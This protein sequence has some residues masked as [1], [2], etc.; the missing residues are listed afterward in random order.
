MIRRIIASLLVSLAPWLSAVDSY[1]RY[2]RSHPSNLSHESVNTDLSDYVWPTDAGNIGTSTFGEYRRTH[3]HEGIDIST[4]NT[5]GY[6]V[7]AVRDGYVARIRI[8]PVGYGKMLYVRHADGY[9]STYAHLSHF[10][11]EIDSVARCEQLKQGSFPVDLLCL[12]NQIPVKKGEVIA[13]TG[14][15]GVGTA[16][17]HF[18]IRDENLEPINPLLCT[19]F[20]F[21]DRIPPIIKRIEISP[22]GSRSTINGSTSPHFFAVRTVKK[23]VYR[24]S[25]TIQLNGE[26]GFGICATDLSNGSRY[27]HGVYSHQLF[28]DD[29]LTYTVQLDRVPAKNAHEIG[30]YYDWSLRDEGKGRYEKLY[31]D[32]PSSLVF[33]SPRTP[34]A[35]VL[36]TS[37][38]PEGT[39][40]FRIVSTDFNDNSAEVTG[41]LI[42][43]HTPLFEI[44]HD[45]NA[46]RIKFDDISAVSKVLMFTRKNGAESWNLKTMTPVP[47]AEGNV[48]RVAEAARSFDVV[49]VEAENAWGARS[50][51][52]F[53]FLRKPNGPSGSITIEHDIHPDF[54]RIR[55]KATGP[56][57]AAPIVTVYEGNSKRTINLT[58]TDID[59]YAGSFHPMESFAGTRRIA[60]EAEVNGRTVTSVKEFELYPI[61]AGASGTITLDGGR[62]IIRYDSTSVFK[63]IFMQVERNR[64]DGPSYSL[65]PENAVLRGELQVTVTANEPR[66]GRGLFFSG[67]GGWELLDGSLNEDKTTFRGS[68]TRTLGEIALRTDETPPT[69]SRLSISRASAG[70]PVI[71]FR[72]GDNLSGVEYKEL[73]TYIDGIAVIPEVD[74]EHHRVTYKAEHPLERGSHRL[75]IRMMDKM[76][77]SNRVER[78]F[79]IR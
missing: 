5:T 61:V 2:P 79:S 56:I 33:Y 25:E 53:C 45:P 20:S 40:T 51:P 23:S 78:Q 75:T 9:Y 50:L 34:N 64:D 28:I 76:G 69:V 73:K 22:L 70:K 8:S 60:A 11:R 66:S 72:Y 7:F 47:Y 71:S 55:L 13:Y 44:E 68:I 57:T 6:R 43:N 59:S 1:A 74:G 46:L 39:H 3:F 67:L 12:P 77:N 63:T 18:E 26:F 42:I 4:G 58:A 62:C 24:V 29:K 52:E 41:K 30:L 65:L 19:E 37:E 36:N 10:S 31:A 16:H 49:K 32:S 14:D 27:K 15:T 35:G 17:L 54:V 38:L 21:P 48:I